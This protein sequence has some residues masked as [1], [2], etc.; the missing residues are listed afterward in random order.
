MSRYK[1]DSAANPIS[2]TR[3]NTYICI[4][5]YMHNL[6]RNGEN[7]EMNCSHSTVIAFSVIDHALQRS[8]ADLSGHAC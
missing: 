4:Y 3:D 5:V 2:Y 6:G 8:G 1:C 7:N